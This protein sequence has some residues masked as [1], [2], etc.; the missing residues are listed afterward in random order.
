M[1]MSWLTTVCLCGFD[2]NVPQLLPV[3]SLHQCLQCAVKN[4]QKQILIHSEHSGVL[5]WCAFNFVQVPSQSALVMPS[6]QWCKV[7]IWKACVQ[8]AQVSKKKIKFTTWIRTHDLMLASHALYQFSYFSVV[9]C[10]LHFFVFRMQ[11]DHHIN[12]W[13]QR[14]RRKMMGLWF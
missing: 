5:R 3:F 14:W 1:Q 4:K 7:N 8:K 9:A 11:A 12:L 10:L 2:R 13:W 6:K